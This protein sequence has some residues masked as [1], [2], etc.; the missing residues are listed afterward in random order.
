M[1]RVSFPGERGAYSEDAARAFFDQDIETVPLPSFAEALGHTVSARTDLAILP[2]EN[3]IEG[4]V[5]EGYDLLYLT[6]LKVIGEIYH[7]IEHCL[8]GSGDLDEVDTVYSHPQAL[9]QC[10]GFLLQRKMR[11]VP[12]YDTAGSVKI[13]REM[14]SRSVACIASRSA[15]E[16]YALPVIRDGIADNPDNFTRFLILARERCEAEDARKTSIIFSLR[17]EPGALYHILDKFL[18]YGVNMTKIESRPKKDTRWEYNFF[19]DFE[20][21]SADTVK[22]MLEQIS[23]DVTFVKALGTYPAAGRG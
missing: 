2:V 7:R 19:M 18:A 17:H 6:P 22:E 9:G 16:A 13:V 23:D 4:S 20:G 11:V 12:A 14:N 1:I 10:R 15:S 21:G 8:I 3:S 5:G